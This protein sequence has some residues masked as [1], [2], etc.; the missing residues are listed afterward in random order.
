M[1]SLDFLYLR[2]QSS[3]LW[4][5][6]IC[7]LKS[8]KRGTW[9]SNRLCVVTSNMTHERGICLRKYIL[10]KSNALWTSEIFAF[11]WVLF[12]CELP[13]PWGC[14]SSWDHLGQVLPRTKCLE[15]NGVQLKIRENIF[16]LNYRHT[17]FYWT[18]LY[19][20]LQILH[21]LQIQGVSSKSLGA[22]FPTAFAR[23]MSLCHIFVILRNSHFFII[24][25]FVRE[26]VIRD[27][28]C[29]YRNGL[30]IYFSHQVFLTKV[31]TLFFTFNV[32]IHLT[33][34]ST[35]P[36]APLCLTLLRP[37]GL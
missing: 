16:S 27:L 24:I 20:T 36:V 30:G 26:S 8:C 9:F 1:K 12:K 37:H 29:Y 2:S 32:I 14:Q 35:C 6:A 21:F 33:E 18:L 7:L 4:K 13:A 3:V 5:Q 22:I 11:W 28:R 10:V 34:Y 17:S 25:I 15:D 31:W 19:C 23:F